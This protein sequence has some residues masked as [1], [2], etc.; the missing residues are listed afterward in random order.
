MGEYNKMYNYSIETVVDAFKLKEMS[1]NPYDE[2]DL[3]QVSCS[4]IEIYSKLNCTYCKWGVQ[5]PEG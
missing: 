2:V 4:K 1:E 5:E 3:L